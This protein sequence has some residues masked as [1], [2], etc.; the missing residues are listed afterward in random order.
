MTKRNYYRRLASYVIQKSWHVS[1]TLASA[2]SLLIPPLAQWLFPEWGTRMTDFVWQVPLFVL[3]ALTLVRGFLAP[4]WMYQEQERETKALNDTHQ[5]TEAELRQRI[6]ELTAQPDTRAIR[7]EQRETLARFIT[8]G[9]Q[10]RQTY[11]TLEP[12]TEAAV[13][14]WDTEV[15]GY[16]DRTF[17]YDYAVLFQRPDKPY[18]RSL[19]P[20]HMS[21]E[22]YKAYLF[23]NMRFA[24]LQKR[25][26]ELRD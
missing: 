8:K 9:I 12:R 3:A 11:E 1:D 15:C 17:G 13:K 26:E 7:R 24:Q 19:R 10:I 25:I 23:F 2:I 16:L 21:E 4:Y 20:S 5:K 18:I 14:E 22:N 6:A